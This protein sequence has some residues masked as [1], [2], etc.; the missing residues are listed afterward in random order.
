MLADFGTRFFLL[1][2]YFF[3]GGCQF[4]TGFDGQVTGGIVGAAGR[5]VVAGFPLLP[6]S[7]VQAFLLGVWMALEVAAASF[8]VG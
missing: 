4:I 1:V 6:G 3:F 7:L 8:L 5:L 2:G